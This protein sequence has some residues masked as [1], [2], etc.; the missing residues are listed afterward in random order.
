[1]EDNNFFDDLDTGFDVKAAQ[2]QAEDAKAKSEKLDHLIHQV[3][4]QS[5][6]GRELLDLWE[7]TLIMSSGAEPGMDMIGI[8]IQEGYKRFI[9][10]IKLTVK[11]VENP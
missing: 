3:F 2:R 1:M 8:G 9:R 11:R 10:N 6:A 5:K 7:Q 4:Q